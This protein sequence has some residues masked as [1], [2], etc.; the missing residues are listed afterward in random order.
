LKGTFLLLLRSR[1]IGEYG[2]VAGNDK[3]KFFFSLVF[4][5]MQ[6]SVCVVGI[7][8]FILLPLFLDFY[9]RDGVINPNNTQ[10]SF[11]TLHSVLIVLII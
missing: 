11:W 2:I 3:Q 5:V 9:R 7:D 4:F 10:L 1:R 8:T 6:S